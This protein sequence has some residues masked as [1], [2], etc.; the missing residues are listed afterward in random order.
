[1]AHNGT[2]ILYAKKFAFDKPAAVARAF[3]MPGSG[4]DALLGAHPVAGL[5][6]F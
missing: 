6:L 2:L 3:L 1:V 4:G 5:Y